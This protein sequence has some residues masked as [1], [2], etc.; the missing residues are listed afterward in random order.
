MYIQRFLALLILISIPTL[1]NAQSKKP[2]HILFIGNSYTYQ[3][4][5]PK[6][7]TNLAKA[8]NQQ[9]VITDRETPGGCTFKRHWDNGKALKKIQSKNW[10]IVILQNHSLGALNG[11]KDMFIYGQKLHDAAKKQGAQVILYMTWARQHKPEMIQPISQAYSQLA[12]KLNAKVA[13]VGLVWQAVRK[14]HPKTILHKSDK[15]HPT[16]VGSYLTAC[17]F[18]ATIFHRSPEGLPGKFGGISDQEARPLQELVWATVSKNG[19]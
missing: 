3:N 7:V 12:E 1:G 18:Y 6:L 10:D 17:V 9:P 15:S 4:D 5:L 8:G 19:N 2:L 11:K 16:K 14:S 13:P